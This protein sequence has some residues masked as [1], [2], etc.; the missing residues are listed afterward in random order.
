MA[1]LGGGRWGLT[2]PVSGVGSAFLLHS[3][4]IGEESPEVK[5]LAVWWP[6]CVTALTL[7]GHSSA[8][9]STQCPVPGSPPE[10]SSSVY[11]WMQ[12]L[13]K[14]SQILTTPS[15][16]ATVQM[17]VVGSGYSNSPPCYVSVH[18]WKKVLGSKVA[19][20]TYTLL[21][22]YSHLDTPTCSL[23]QAA[24]SH[25]LVSSWEMPPQAFG[26]WFR[27]SSCCISTGPTS[28]SCPAPEFFHP[29]P[30]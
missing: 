5:P 12:R 13:T 16:H 15:S 25:P 11:S 19:P 28:I 6:T 7:A 8:V 29:I 14:Y 10:P 26:V 23:G 20:S 17:A 22:R 24:L 3:V 21:W 30:L 27:W 18:S 4:A 2:S 1:T 9:T